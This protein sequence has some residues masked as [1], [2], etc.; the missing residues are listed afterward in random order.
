M[1]FDIRSRELL[2]CFSVIILIVRGHIVNLA[3]SCHLIIFKI[4]IVGGN[5]IDKRSV[6]QKLDNSVRRRL[7]DL[8][9]AGCKQ[10]NARE[11]NQSVV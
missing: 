4:F 10:D 2:F 1:N 3:F 8:M 9:V 11:F 6:R 7:Y 5:L